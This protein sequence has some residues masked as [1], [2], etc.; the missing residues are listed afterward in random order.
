MVACV[1]DVRA[2]RIPNALVVVILLSG[3][4][5]S[6]STW[7]L[8]VALLRSVEGVGL[9]FAIWVAFWL[10]G[11]LGAGDVKFFAAAGAWLGPGPTWRAALIAALLGGVLAVFTL[12]RQRR[13]QAGVERTALALSSRSLGVLGATGDDRPGL[14]RH[15]PYGVALAGGALVAA[16][17]PKIL[18]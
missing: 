13:L 4:A 5:F 15:L 6:V 8:S 12:L 16:W 9:G 10:L 1:T 18:A 2:R 14:K 3:V 7:P 11:M 17:F